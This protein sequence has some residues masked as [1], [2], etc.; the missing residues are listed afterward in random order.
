MR[1]PHEPQAGSMT[2]SPSCGL[3]ILTAIF[4]TGRG[5]KYWPF[6]PFCSGLIKYSN[7]ASTTSKAV[8]V[9]VYGSSAAAQSLRASA[10][11]LDP[12]AWIE[13]VA[14]IRSLL[15]LLKKI[16]EALVDDFGRGGWHS[17]FDCIAGLALG[18]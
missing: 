6:C 8:C 2:S 17:E 18:A 5:V 9:S 10:P 15:R 16:V 12:L 14:P 13:H 3:S 4:T 11:E 1:K 7:A